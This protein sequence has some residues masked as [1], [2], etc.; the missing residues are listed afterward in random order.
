MPPDYG[1]H[2]SCFSRPVDRLKGVVAEAAADQS[3][4]LES[5]NPPEK[6]QL[7]LVDRIAATSELAKHD[8]ANRTHLQKISPYLLFPHAN[9][10]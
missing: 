7:L 4:R 8:Q 6:A 10:A 2:F 1:R 9:E 3:L 5:A